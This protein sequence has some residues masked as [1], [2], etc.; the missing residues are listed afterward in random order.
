MPPRFS[1]AELQNWG[2]ED[3]PDLLV[4]LA[5]NRIEYRLESEESPELNDEELFILTLYEL[6]SEVN[7]GGSYFW[8][9]NAGERARFAPRFLNSL[10]V[11]E[12][13]SIV[14]TILQT[15][16]AEG[17]STDIATLRRQ[18]DALPASFESI[19]S[20]ADRRFAGLEE[21][22]LE[23]LYAYCRRNL[24]KVRADWA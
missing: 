16:G 19:C 6:Y 9:F 15:F 10:G 5:H 2:E 12:L 3:N 20:D 24:A 13:G 14:E 7:N 4:E 8:L 23:R 22:F 1:N 18:L 11:R 21:D 17:P